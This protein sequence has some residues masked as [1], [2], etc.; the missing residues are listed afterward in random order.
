MNL[1]NMKKLTFDGVELK[2]LSINGVLAWK[3]GY[4]NWVPYST[5]NDG[6]TIYNGGLGY[7]EGYRVR[8]GGTESE[9]G[10]IVCTGFIPYKKGD[11]LRLYP[12]YVGH[13]NANAFS[14]ADANFNTLGQITDIATLYGICNDSVYGA[15]WLALMK[16]MIAQTGDITTLDISGIGNAGDIA[17]VRVNVPFRA[18][19]NTPYVQSGADIIIT[20]NEE[21]TL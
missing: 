7:K 13:N 19:K 1:T 12:K 16:A 20:V 3:S 11:I 14:F 4:K 18:T 9:N 17:Y 2:S 10:E 5:T 6:K 15:Q 21:L 8:S